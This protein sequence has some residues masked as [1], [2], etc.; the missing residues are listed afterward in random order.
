MPRLDL[1]LGSGRQADI[2]TLLSLVEDIIRQQNRAGGEFYTDVCKR[3]GS[4]LLS[5]GSVELQ[6]NSFL[7]NISVDCCICNVL[8]LTRVFNWNAFSLRVIG[9]T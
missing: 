3:E 2:N 4:L 9:D 8:Y 7:F 6:G 5:L 1:E